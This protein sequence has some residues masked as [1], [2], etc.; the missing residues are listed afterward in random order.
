MNGNLLIPGTQFWNLDWQTP[1][2]AIVTETS[3]ELGAKGIMFDSNIGESEWSTDFVD[4]L[5]K[6]TTESA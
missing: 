1:A 4:M 5:Y 2:A 3:F 6:D